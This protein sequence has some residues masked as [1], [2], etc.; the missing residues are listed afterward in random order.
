[1]KK[2]THSSSKAPAW[3]PPR[4]QPSLSLHRQ[5]LYLDFLMLMN[6][7]LFI[8]YHSWN[9]KI[10]FKCNVLYIL[11]CFA[12][13]FQHCLKSH[14]CVVLRCSSFILVVVYLIVWHTTISS[15]YC[16]WILIPVHIL[17]QKYNILVRYR[18]RNGDTG[19]L[20]K[21]IFNFIR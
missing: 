15:F 21:P 17:V 8:F 19:S 6:F 11:L 16:W 20:G 2:I 14:L 12:S 7:F 3:V 13:F 4:G 10:L 1:M 18:S 5:T 9:F